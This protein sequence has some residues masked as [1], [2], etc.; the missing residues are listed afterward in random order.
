MAPSARRTRLAN[1]PHPR[2][3]HPRLLT[4]YPKGHFLVPRGHF[5]VP[6]GHFLKGTLPRPEG[7]LVLPKGQ[8]VLPKESSLV[9]KGTPRPEGKL[10]APKERSSPRR[11]TPCPEGKT[12]PPEGKLPRPAGKLLAPKGNSLS[13]RE[14]SSSRR[15]APSSRREAPRPEGKL[16]VPKGRLVPPKESSLAPKG[17]LRPEGK[18]LA[19]K[20]RSSPRREAPRP[21]GKLLVPQGS[22]SSRREAP[23]PAGKLLVSSR[24]LAWHSASPTR[25]TCWTE[26]R[27]SST[28]LLRRWNP[29]WKSSNIIWGLAERLRMRAVVLHAVGMPFELEE[30]PV[31][32]PRPDEALIKIRACGAGLTVHH[33]KARTSPATLPVIMGHG[34][35]G[36]V[37]EVGSEIDGVAVGDRVTPHFYLFCG[38][39]RY[40][41]TMREPL[42]ENT[43][44]YIGRQRDGGY[45][46]YV[47]LP[48][49]NL[50]KIP[51]DLPY[52]AHREEVAVICDAIATPYKV[53]RRARVRPLED[54]L[55]IGAAGGVGI[56][57]F[58]LARFAGG[59]VLAADRG[60]ARLAAAKDAGADECI[61]ALAGSVDA[62]A[63][64][65]T[66][67]WSW[68]R[69]GRGLRRDSRYFIGRLG[70]A[71]TG[72]AA[73]HPRRP[74]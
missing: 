63:R 31:P 6:R 53:I 49:R 21:A 47:A 50:V 46:E 26:R 15:K 33:A 2:A 52:D 11:E 1:S 25:F 28:A 64:Q 40:C 37:V 60:E 7:K 30:P 18:L 13:R 56:H 61:D 58:Q 20:E 3:P 4:G 23:R 38:R 65:L 68:R 51:S 43:G 45:A 9:P 57:V 27:L 29:I 70:R 35:A 41:T 19:P 69:R 73:G 8:L 17:T 34:I 71:C 62:Q 5:L 12:R 55:V 59:R 14:D 24:T 42:C 22:S 54:V 16:L 72:R 36:E 10:L 39:C 66:D 32:R 74:S 44:G 48:A 67:G